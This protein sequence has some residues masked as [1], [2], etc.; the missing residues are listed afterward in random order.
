MRNVLSIARRECRAYFT[1]AIGYVVMAAFIA[2]T[3]LIFFLI[4]SQPQ[5]VASM[6]GVFR[7]L[8][9]LLVMLLPL[10]TMR[11]LAGERS[12]DQGIGTIELLLTSPITEW[13]L[14]L[15]KFVGSLL[16]IFALLA[17][18]LIYPFTLGRIG[19]PDLGTIFAGYVGLLFFCG[20]CLAFGLFLSS[21]T[22]SQ[23]VAAISSIVG[24]LV[25]WLSKFLGE[26][27]GGKLGWLAWWSFMDHHEDF[28]RGLITFSD[29]AWYLS[30]IF[31]FL[32]A[33]KQMIASSR[34]R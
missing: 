12:G 1:S 23:I 6:D 18:S 15:G 30:F 33:A 2:F 31:F 22:N 20:Y 29:C 14:V 8:A 27:G 3:G 26:V 28:W 5:A 9:I 17:V 13:E 16:Y 24:L 4:V 34:W 7:N 21:L 19:D 10:L 25:I 11:L 32:F